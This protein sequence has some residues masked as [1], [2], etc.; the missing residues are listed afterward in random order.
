MGSEDFNIDPDRKNVVVIESLSQ[1]L[2]LRQG[3]GVGNF[4]ENVRNTR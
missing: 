2:Y 3:R 1:L 4:G